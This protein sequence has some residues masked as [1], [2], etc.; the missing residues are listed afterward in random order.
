MVNYED[1]IKELEIFNSNGSESIIYSD[2]VYI[3]KIFRETKKAYLENKFR[4]VNLLS[5]LKHFEGGVLPIEP[6]LDI[7]GNFKGYK[8]DKIEGILLA[9][10]FIKGGIYDF[11]LGLIDSSVKLSKIHSRP[12]DI[13]LGDVNCYNIILESRYNSCFLDLDNCQIDKLK[14]DNY[15]GILDTFCKPRIKRTHISKNTDRL[16]QLLY[17]IRYL[18]EDK[19]SLYELDL[20]DF[21][22]KREEIRSLSNL[23]SL[24]FKLKDFT[25]SVPSIPYIFE[26]IDEEE[27]KKLKRGL[28]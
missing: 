15:S 14:Y 24:L 8:A 5:S 25:K 23:R 21:D 18:F 20:Y 10:I 11:I 16:I 28:N 1:V 12:E 19:T 7:R 13:I 22:Q 6:I 27:V 9:D 3:Y 26:I 2:D 4:K 17:L